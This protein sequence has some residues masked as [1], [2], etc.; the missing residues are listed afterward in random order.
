MLRRIGTWVESIRESF[1]GAAPVD[2]GLGDKSIALTR[3]GNSLY[4]HLLRDPETTSVFLRPLTTRPKRATLLNDGRVLECD[5]TLLP[6]W[7]D[8]QPSAALRVRPIPVNDATPYGRVLRLD[9]EAFPDASKT[10]TTDET[11]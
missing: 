8:Q 1:D 9:F 2:L 6:R 7:H 3:R 5:I 10:T 4:V 11:R